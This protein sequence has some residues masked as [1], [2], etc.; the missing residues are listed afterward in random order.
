MCPWSAPATLEGRIKSWR[1]LIYW[2]NS[3]CEVLLCARDGAK[4]WGHKGGA[5]E[6][7]QSNRDSRSTNQKSPS[8]LAVKG[9]HGRPGKE[10][11]ACCVSWKHPAG[12]SGISAEPQTTPNPHPQ[13]KSHFLG[14]PCPS[15]GAS[16]RNLAPSHL[17]YGLLR[18]QRSVLPRNAFWSH[19]PSFKTSI[20]S[21]WVKCSKNGCQRL[22]NSVN[23]L[24]II[25]CVLKMGE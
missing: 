20:P 11:A 3:D 9:V 21:Y 5:G 19:S 2:E 18:T 16:P 12:G 23:L 24:K 6:H 15:G 13:S 22:H 1:A 8:N 4:L 17:P 7:A 25:S 10:A 14:L